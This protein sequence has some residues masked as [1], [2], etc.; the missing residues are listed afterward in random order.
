MPPEK[1]ASKYGYPH[2]RMAAAVHQR[3][4]DMLQKGFEWTLQNGWPQNPVPTR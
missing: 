2:P 4:K 3:A 1:I